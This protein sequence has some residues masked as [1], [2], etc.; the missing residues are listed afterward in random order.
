VT[1]DAAL[2][3]A[4]WDYRRGNFAESHTWCRQLLNYPE[5]DAVQNATARIIQALACARLNQADEA[6]VQLAQ[7][8]EVVEKKLTPPLDEGSKADGFWFDW[9][10]ARVLLTEAEH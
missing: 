2:T 3:L 6:K 1:A 10:M 5:C 4:L 7:A 8:T 9:V